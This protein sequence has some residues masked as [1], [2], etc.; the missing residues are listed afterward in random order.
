MQWVLIHGGK[1]DFQ[2]AVVAI[3]DGTASV[4]GAGMFLQHPTEHGEIILAND[5]DQVVHSVVLGQLPE[6]R[7]GCPEIEKLPVHRLSCFRAV[8]PQGDLEGALQASQDVP[9]IQLRCGNHTTH[10][11]SKKE[12]CSAEPSG[13]FQFLLYSLQVICQQVLF[14]LQCQVVLRLQ[15]CRNFA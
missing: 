14:L 9:R 5:N 3:D 11:L 7:F 6:R 12:L 15:C 1:V 4:P 10:P 8:V 13:C 2:N